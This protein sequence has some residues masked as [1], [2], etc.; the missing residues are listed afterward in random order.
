MSVSVGARYKALMTEPESDRFQRETPRRLIAAAADEFNAQ[1]FDGTDTNRIA[2]RAGFAP[3][4]FYRW[5]SDKTDIF[6]RVY[7]AWQREEVDA[8][9]ALLAE[10]ADDAALV[11]V[12]IAHHTA[13][14]QFRRSLRRLAIEDPRVRAARASSRQRQIAQ[15]SA[16]RPERRPED[17]AAR[18]L[19][20]E[21]LAD[22][23]AEGEFADMGMTDIAAE[24]EL[25]RL[26]RELRGRSG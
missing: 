25:A 1:G 12:C 9:Q 14:R 21:R 11:R 22:A 8:L 10:A 26:I 3:Q 20:V 4:T 16:L 23:I 24:R 19:Q 7:E 5:F 2:R 15:L 13:H 17:L 18:L 6:I